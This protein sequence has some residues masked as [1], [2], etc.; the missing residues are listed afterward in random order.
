MSVL[1]SYGALLPGIPHNALQ[2]GESS[3]PPNLAKFQ[4]YILAV[5]FCP[6]SGPTPEQPTKLPD[7]WGA[8]VLA[9]IRVAYLRQRWRFQT[10]SAPDPC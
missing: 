5:N 2:N 4:P 7:L 9:L 6:T 10:N 3:A 8:Q 1:Q